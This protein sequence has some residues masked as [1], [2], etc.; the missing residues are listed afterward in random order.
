MK[1]R[2]PRRVI[3]TR[4]LSDIRDSP[5]VLVSGNPIDKQD[6]EESRCKI[7]ITGPVRLLAPLM[8]AIIVNPHID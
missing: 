8:D 1:T 2:T 5:D 3:M 7:T 6:F 4:L